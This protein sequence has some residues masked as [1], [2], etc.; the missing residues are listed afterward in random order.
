MEQG[1]R[2]IFLMR[3]ALEEAE[4]ALNHEEIPVGCVFALSPSNDTI[5]TVPE[6]IVAGS[7]KTNQTRNGTSHAEIVAIKKLIDQVGSTKAC[8]L[9][10]R[11]DLYVTCEPCIMCAAALRRLGIKTVYFGCSNDR[12]G[13][14]GSILS[15]HD[16][17]TCFV[18]GSQYNVVRGLMEK[19]AIEIFQ[20]FYE[21]ENRRAPEAKRKKKPKI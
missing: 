8:D 17:S 2:D 16:D 18:P 9:I 12:F 7:N 3:R 6:I 21:S 19:E 1:G 15:V 4:Y 5:A 10:S 11:C 20:R 14:N 13:G